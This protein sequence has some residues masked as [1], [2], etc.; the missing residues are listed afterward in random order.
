MTFILFPVIQLI[1]FLSFLL[2]NEAFKRTLIT[3]LSI[4]LKV[5]LIGRRSICQRQIFDALKFIQQKSNQEACICEQS[6]QDLEKRS[7]E[8]TNLY[9]EHLSTSILEW[10][11][12][13]GHQNHK[14]LDDV[15]VI[16][17]D[18]IDE[19]LKQERGLLLLTLHLGNWEILLRKAG[20][21]RHPVHVI[22][23]EMHQG[24]SQIL[25]QKL[26]LGGP[27]ILY[28]KRQAFKIAKALKQ[29]EIVVDVLDQ[30]CPKK[31]AIPCLFFGKK[32]YTQSDFLRWQSLIG[33]EVLLIYTYRKGHRHVIE[34]RKI[35]LRL[36]NSIEERVQQV[37]IA[38]ENLICEHFEQWLWIHR[39]WK[40]NAK[41][42]I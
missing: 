37:M 40:E 31:T 28:G 24:L 25:L 42:K 2:S 12:I 26:R 6:S 13:F 21:F 34:V 14:I 16:G 41:T 23:K 9:F 35:D 20:A 4:C 8:Q 15:E 30:H 7:K 17:E 5:I 33:S 36:T 32:A 11:V 1:R 10:I 29:N 18:L 38:Y 3:P 27:S 22:S 19:A 39:R